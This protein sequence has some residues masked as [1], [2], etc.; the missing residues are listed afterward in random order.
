MPKATAKKFNSLRGLI[1]SKNS[2]LIDKAKRPLIELKVKN[3]FNDV[4]SGYKT[5][6][7]QLKSEVV[8]LLLSPT[9]SMEAVININEELE[10]ISKKVTGVLALYETIFGEKL[11][12]DKAAF[13]I[14][15][16]S[17]LI[18]EAANESADDSED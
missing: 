7:L 12:I 9:L 16:G 14:K 1:Q 15:I 5:D 18:L 13:D 3:D 4:L 10:E 17:D 8:D 2:K 11:T 6:I